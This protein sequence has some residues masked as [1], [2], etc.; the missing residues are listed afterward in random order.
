MKRTVKDPTAK[1]FHFEDLESLKAH[2]LALVATYDFAKRLKALHWKTPFQTVCQASTVDPS[3][4]RI[5]WRYLVP[6]SYTLRSLC[7]AGR[8]TAPC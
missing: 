2:V 4:F 6:G 3:R 8:P 1:V 7:E 5:N